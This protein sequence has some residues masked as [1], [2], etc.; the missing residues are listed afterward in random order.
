MEFS[1]DYIQYRKRSLKVFKKIFLGVFLLFLYFLA[2]NPGRIETIF[3]LILIVSLSGIY[4]Y[5]FIKKCR[6]YLARIKIFDDNCEFV[7]YEYD[8]IK[9]IH[10]TK[11]SET[12]IKIVMLLFPFTH[13]GTS[14]K[15]VVEIKKGAVYQ[16]LIQ[17]YEIGGW[18]LDKF[19]EVLALYGKT[20]GVPVSPQSYKRTMF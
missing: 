18:H 15:L 11:L 9:E 7:V 2:R 20:K 8:E 10:R 4:F 13:I 1:P 12:R 3:L 17:Q 19:K 16:V 14:Y 5:S 6:Y